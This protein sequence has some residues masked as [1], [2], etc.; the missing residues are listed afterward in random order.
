MT[1]RNK[2]LEKILKK[3]GLKSWF[4][5]VD[6]LENSDFVL[7][8]NKRCRDKSIVIITEDYKNKIERGET[9]SPD[10]VYFLGIINKRNTQTIKYALI[11]GNKGMFIS[12]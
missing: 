12:N 11:M 10:F 3:R 8:E 6:S 4:K 1:D 5:I 7:I 2:R 9:Y